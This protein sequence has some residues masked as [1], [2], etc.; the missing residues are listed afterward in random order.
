MIQSAQINFFGVKMSLPILIVFERHWDTIPKTLIKD[1]LPELSKRGYETVCFEAPQDLSTAEINDRQNSAL[2]RDLDIQQQ[3]EKLLKQVGI[4]SKLSD[5]SFSSLAE[6]L[7][8]YVSSKKYE[9]V[10]EKIKQLSASRILKEIFGEATKLPMSLKGIDIN[11]K[12]FD[13]ITSVDL[14]RRMSVINLKEDQRISTMFQNLLKLRT[15]QKEGV[16]FI[17]GARHAK[18][19]IDQFKKRGLQDEVLYYFPHSSSRYDESMDDI[20]A[21]VNDSLDTLVDHTHL[22]DQ[23]DIEQFGKRVIREITEKTKY[24]KEILDYNSHSRFLSDCFK[25]NFRAFLRPGYHVDALVDVTEP[26]DIEDIQ[27]R[28]SATGVQTHRI[29]LDGRNY[30]V[31]PNVNTG[32]IAEKIRKI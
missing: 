32:D 11:S 6:L 23:K 26:S 21:L 8:L 30:L 25:T 10:A 19:L 15:Q 7:R 29:T 31:I 5:M 24:T 12:D 4:T 3:A 2:E 17:C 22:L 14:S 27:K 9:Y 20:E 1:L 13:K 18:G 16:I 28:V